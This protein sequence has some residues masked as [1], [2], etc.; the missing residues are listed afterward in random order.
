[1]A[2]DQSKIFIDPAQ[3]RADLNFTEA[4]LEE[5]QFKQASLFAH[6]A[7]LYTEAQHHFDTLKTLLE[8]EEARIGKQARNDGLVSGYKSTEAQVADEVKGDIKIITL[9]GR[10]NSAR[11]QME[12][13][14]LACEA[15]KQ[16]R[17]MLVQIG[18]SK[19]EERAGELRIQAIKTGNETAVDRAKAI[20]QDR[21]NSAA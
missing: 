3:L 18:V 10:I 12:L 4:T 16:R 5:A 15:F 13:G 8:I 20:A 6:Y 2:S 9:K 21:K 19:R 17:D 11:A 14:K 7:V 1:M